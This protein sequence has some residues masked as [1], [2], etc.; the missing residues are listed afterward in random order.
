M[1]EK[2]RDDSRIVKKATR[3]LRLRQAMPISRRPYESNPASDSPPY[4]SEE[5]TY[6]VG[7]KCIRK[8]DDAERII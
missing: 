1:A 8:M 6:V 2:N 5:P 4:R 7:R 3:Q